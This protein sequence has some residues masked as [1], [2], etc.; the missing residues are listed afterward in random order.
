V[1]ISYGRSGRF[2]LVSVRLLALSRVETNG[3]QA[4]TD[5]LR[6][7]RSRRVVPCGIRCLVIDWLETADENR[8]ADAM[9]A[10]ALSSVLEMSVFVITR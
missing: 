7:R 2:S 1:S 4:R 3:L 10:T 6:T 5:V 9:P 8:G